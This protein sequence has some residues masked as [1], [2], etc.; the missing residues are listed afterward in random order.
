MDEAFWN[1]GGWLTLLVFTPLLGAALTT[2][3]SEET[4][5]DRLQITR[6]ALG[7]SLVTLALAAPLAVA[8][9]P[10]APGFQFS[11]SGVGVPGGRT[12]VGVD[13]FSLPLVLL[14]AF[15][16]PF[17]V[18]AS[19][20]PGVFSLKGPTLGAQA[21]GGGSVK[22][23][24]ACLLASAGFVLGALL[25]VDALSFFLFFELALIPTL[26]WLWWC[27]SAETRSEARRAAVRLAAPL[28]LSAALLAAALWWM[29]GHVASS[30]EFA[31]RIVATPP[32]AP[33]PMATDLRVWLSLDW[34]SAPAEMVGLTAPS[35]A[36][37]ALFLAFLVAFAIKAGLWPTQGWLP[38]V[39]AAAPSG[40][41][42]FV[43]A[44]V[45]KLGLYGFLRFSFPMAPAASADFAWMM[46]ALGAAGLIYGAGLAATRE[47]LRRRIGHFTVALMG[48]ALL[49]VFSGSERGVAGALLQLV[50]HGLG[51]TALLL[52]LQPNP[53][54]QPNPRPS[55]APQRPAPPSVGRAVA[56]AAILVFMLGMIGAP[57]GPGFVA[58]ALTLEGLIEGLVMGGF[59]LDALGTGVWVGGA[60]IGL[61]GLGLLILVWAAWR[62]QGRGLEFHGLRLGHVMWALPLGAAVLTLGVAPELLTALSAD[63]VAR[64][65]EAVGAGVDPTAAPGFESMGG[66]PARISGDG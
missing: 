57:G 55:G 5:A 2:V 15:V 64:L 48:V 6:F 19:A 32:G 46:V 41:A 65:I 53:L 13:G 9:D 12:L 4:E 61:L 14:A 58:T 21:A 27:A 33:A 37:T 3:F 60:L 47:P 42:L 26:L 44:A 51:V 30:P 59:A 22:A 29:T 17:A 52:L 24:M 50:S 25:A 8:F 10:S 38:T 62:L 20:P 56:P 16:T 40:L 34:P 35:G 45:I 23:L 66:D 54:S 36:Q 63:A 18:L 28:V 1:G 11:G 31:A 7:V 39:L 49:G 43:A